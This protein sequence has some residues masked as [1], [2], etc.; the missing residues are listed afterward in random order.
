MDV[1]SI[2]LIIVAV[3]AP[4]AGVVAFYLQLK[5]LKKADLENQKLTLELHRLEQENQRLESLIHRPTDEEIRK[6]GGKDRPMFSRV[7]SSDETP[8]ESIFRELKGFDWLSLAAAVFIVVFIAY[9]FF[10]IY[11][12]GKWIIGL[13]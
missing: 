6:Y 1:E 4:I 8:E 11:R 10:D 13:F 7:S 9:L 3:S 5:N 2:W 12:I